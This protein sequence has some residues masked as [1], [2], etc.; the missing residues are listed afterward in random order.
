ML[1]AVLVIPYVRE[2]SNE[3]EKMQEYKEKMTQARENSQIEKS[4]I[5]RSSKDQK[6]Q[7][8]KFL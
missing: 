3:A 1:T 6:E 5:V 7:V 4:F 2:C 8:K